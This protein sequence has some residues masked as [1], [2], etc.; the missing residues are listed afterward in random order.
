MATDKVCGPQYNRGVGLLFLSWLNPVRGRTEWILI[1]LRY[2]H[3]RRGGN[4]ADYWNGY[5][6]EMWSK[7]VVRLKRSYHL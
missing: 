7:T 6:E 4:L 2:V 3:M 5:F 1:S